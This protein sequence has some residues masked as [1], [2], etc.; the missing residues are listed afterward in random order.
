MSFTYRVYFVLIIGIIKS[1]SSFSQ[2][3][4]IDKIDTNGYVKKATWNGNVSLGLEV[5][6]QKATLFDA[7]NFVDVSLQ[8]SHELFIFSASERYTYNGPEDFLNAGYLHLRWRHN[9]RDKWHPETF[10]QYQWDNGRGIVHRYL[11]GENLRYNLWHNHD[12]EMSIA[13]GLMYENEIWNYVA[14]DSSKIPANHPD[15]HSSHIK[16]NSYIKWD[17]KVSAN[18]SLAFT[19]YYQALFNHFFQPRIASN[20]DFNVAVSKHFLLDVKLYSLYDDAPV[21]PIFKFY[22]NFSYNLVYKF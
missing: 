20:L 3:I 7:S 12:W 21:V 13:T 15:V 2:I 16:S 4:N 22:Y 10:V 18:S 19:V 1:V 8:K 5:D 14:V 6:K 9:Y 17:T 11:L